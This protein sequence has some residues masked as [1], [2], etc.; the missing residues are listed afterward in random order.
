MCSHI[1][2]FLLLCT[3][4]NVA[5]FSLDFHEEYSAASGAVL[6]LQTDFVVLA[7][8]HIMSQYSNSKVW[9][10]RSHSG[11]DMRRTPQACF[12]Y[13]LR[14]RWGLLAYF[15]TRDVA[16]FLAQTYPDAS[17]S[18]LTFCRLCQATFCLAH[19]QC[20][21]APRCALFCAF[22]D[23]VMDE[24]LSEPLPPSIHSCPAWRTYE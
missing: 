18:R 8:D 5:I 24:I 17:I 14:E 3:Q 4:D 7:V 16:R 21:S 23:S 11:K 1:I 9:L 10:R 6:Q 15:L 2:R 19:S 12:E 13:Q 20:F 22:S